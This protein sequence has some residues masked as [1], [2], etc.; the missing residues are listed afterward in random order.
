MRLIIALMALWLMTSGG[1]VLPVAGVVVMAGIV[2][3]L[4]AR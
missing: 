4:M 2:T 3:W 1:F